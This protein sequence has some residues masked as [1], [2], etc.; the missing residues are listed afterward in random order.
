[1]ALYCYLC[2]TSHNVKYDSTASHFKAPCFEGQ[3]EI[4]GDPRDRLG[5]TCSAT[6]ASKNSNFTD[7]PPKLADRRLIVRGQC[8]QDTFQVWY[9]RL[10]RCIFRNLFKAGPYHPSLTCGISY[11]NTRSIVKGWLDRGWKDTG[12]IWLGPWHVMAWCDS[13]CDDFL[14][15]NLDERKRRERCNRD[16]HGQLQCRWL[17]AAANDTSTTWQGQEC[18]H[19]AFE[20]ENQGSFRQGL[21]QYKAR[22]Y[23]TPCKSA[24]H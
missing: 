4:I 9:Q 24:R 2:G 18:R 17:H 23:A 10:K 13:K 6:L 11:V 3:Q 19:H 16:G 5:A 12:A 15:R 20:A 22:Y 8:G 7:C 1:M 21:Q 14:R